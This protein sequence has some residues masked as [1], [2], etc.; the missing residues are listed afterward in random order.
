MTDLASVVRFCQEHN[1][2]ADVVGR[3]VWVRFQSKPDPETRNLLK[4]AGF[5]WVRKRGQW[6]HHCG[7]RTRYNPALADPRDKYGAI[8][9]NAT[10]PGS[11]RDEED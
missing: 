4:G 11:L 9:V 1:L 10:V 3:W 7:Y 8:P 5:R 6:A 2:P